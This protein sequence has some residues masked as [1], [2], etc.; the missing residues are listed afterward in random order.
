MRRTDDVDTPTFE[1]RLLRFLEREE[2]DEQR[3]A[4]E[5]RALSVDERVL[6]GEC[7]AE[8]LCESVEGDAPVF[9]V[10]ENLSK[11]RSGDA[12]L[13]GDGL[14]FDDGYPAVYGRFDAEQQLL[15]VERDRFA[16]VPPPSFEPG[17]RYVIDRRSLGLRNRLRDVVRR[18]F[19]PVEEGPS[20]GDVL[21]GRHAPAFD[22]GRR[23]RAVAALTA[24]GLDAAQVRAGAAAIAAESLALVQGPPGTGKTRLLAELLRTL[25]AAG[26]RI[27]VG[28]FTHRAL[29]NVL[30]ALRRL[31]PSI[32]CVKVGNPGHD[33]V[34]LRRAGVRCLGGGRGTPD[35]PARGVVAG[36]PY[37]LARLVGVA[38]FH[39]AVFDEAGQLPIPH[40]VAG[41]L[42]ARR[43]LFFGDHQQLPPVVTA[44]HA[45]RE[46]A[47]SVF[48]H[49]HAQYGSELL[50]V[51]Y[52]LN[53]GVCRVVSETFYGGRLTPSPTA[54]TRRMPFVAGGVLDDVLDPEQPVVI[55]GIDHR[56]P[57]RRSIE[58]ATL[59]ADLVAELVTRH[60]VA[61]DEI[62]VIAPFRA[63][64]RAIRSALQ[65]R[66]VDDDALVVDTVERI[67]GQEREVVLISL[68]VGDPA[69][70]DARSTFFFSGNRLN[71]ALSRA[72]SKVVLIAADG[73]FRALPPDPEALLAAAV[74]KRLRAELPCFD[75]T[76]V[77]GASGDVEGH[78]T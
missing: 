2:V 46:V 69:T 72:R 49:L 41:M 15:I 8:A 66:G 38:R 7:I 42:L 68:A 53:D 67:Q 44:H 11:F 74:F 6:E 70:L 54:A 59:C 39:F 16:R 50:D 29:D 36:T 78:A 45:D 33:A 26:C 9:R 32:P 25:C 30:L 14:D 73:A 17:R 65:R 56:Q 75:L 77:Y 1:A 43:W 63:Q 51:T 34:Q 23:E 61:A 13:V 21:E 57:G 76:A 48:E 12:V 64:V 28:A 37:A 60:G 20:V 10:D 18:A 55:A 62:A 58:E 22:E 4:D 71:V 31:D 35:L 27:A 52:R 47:R 5:L 24:A 3:T 40:A 19:Q